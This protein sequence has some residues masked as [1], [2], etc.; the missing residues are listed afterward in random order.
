V[1]AHSDKCRLRPDYRNVFR[2]IASRA[3]KG[4]NR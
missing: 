3:A 4:L 1:V 2:F